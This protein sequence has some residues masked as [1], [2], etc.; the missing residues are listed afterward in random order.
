MFGFNPTRLRPLG[1]SLCLRSS[2][3]RVERATPFADFFLTFAGRPRRFSFRNQLTAQ[4]RKRRA[5]ING[6]FQGRECKFH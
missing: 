2:L 1:L 3:P 6:N 5:L 4:L